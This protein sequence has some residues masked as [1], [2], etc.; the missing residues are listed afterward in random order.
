[1]EHLV[2]NPQGNYSKEWIECLEYKQ[3]AIV[4][5]GR[6]VPVHADTLVV[7]ILLDVVVGFFVH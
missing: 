6:V 5:Y 7:V 3:I 1:M 2:A 4:M